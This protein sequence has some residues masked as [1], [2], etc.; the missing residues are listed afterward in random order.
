MIRFVTCMVLLC[1]TSTH[2]FSRDWINTVKDTLVDVYFEKITVNKQNF[3]RDPAGTSYLL[4]TKLSRINAQTR[5]LDL[6]GQSLKQIPTE[7]FKFKNLKILLIGGNPL[8]YLPKELAQMQQ[9]IFLDISNTELE[10]WPAVVSKLSNL[11]FLDCSTNYIAQLPPDIG[12]LRKLIALN[13]YRNPIREISEEIGKLSAL[14]FLN[15]GQ[16]MSDIEEEDSRDISM[17]EADVPIEQP[18]KPKPAQWRA[19]LSERFFSYDRRTVITSLTKLS[20]LEVLVL[21]D[22]L[23]SA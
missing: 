23:M 14:R 4:E 10:Q 3:L 16:D 20:N 12:A 9:L 15:L 5:A 1:S 17:D 21:K 11:A 22:N 18:V 8:V 6:R 7:I 19:F 2:A 13:V